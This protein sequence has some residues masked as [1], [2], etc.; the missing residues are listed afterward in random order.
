M[1][2]NS[3]CT[4]VLVFLYIYIFATFALRVP[5]YVRIFS[6]STRPI[7]YQIPNKHDSTT[8][9]GV[10]VNFRFY[11]T[12]EFIDRGTTRLT[13]LRFVIGQKSVCLTKSEIH[14]V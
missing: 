13:S 1:T 11:T 12:V 2:S 6:S 5:P 14:A 7:E 9:N 8:I 3:S 4:L 10:Y